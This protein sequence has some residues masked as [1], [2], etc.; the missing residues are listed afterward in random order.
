M[1]DANPQIICLAAG[2]ALG[3]FI[4]YQDAHDEAG[5]FVPRFFAFLELLLICIITI[6]FYIYSRPRR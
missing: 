6:M 1:W 3:T 5:N 4:V 2:L